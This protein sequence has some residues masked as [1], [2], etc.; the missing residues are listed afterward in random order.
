MPISYNFCSKQTNTAQLIRCIKEH[1]SEI[2]KAGFQIVATVCD[3]G[4]SNVAA[5]KELLLRTAMKRNFE[6]RPE[7]KYTHDIKTRVC[8]SYGILLRI[9]RK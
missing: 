2:Q 7:S 4:S 3:Q 6:N 9:Y 8:S 5:I 1:I